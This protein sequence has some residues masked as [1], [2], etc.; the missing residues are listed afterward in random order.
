[1]LEANK[2]SEDNGAKLVIVYVPNKFRVH[3]DSCKYPDDGY[4]K[5]WKPNDLPSRLESWCKL[6]EINFLDLTPG[7]KESASR[8][9]LVYFTDD[10]HWTPKGHEVVSDA[11]SRLITQN[12]W[13]E[14]PR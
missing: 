1:M 9:E 12:G 7:L 4:G 2:V 3:C 14:T 8:G 11:L 5:Q 13:L 10:G 6:N